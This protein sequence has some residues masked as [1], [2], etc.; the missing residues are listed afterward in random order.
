MWKLTRKIPL[1]L[2]VCWYWITGSRVSRCK[3][4]VPVWI[5]VVMNLNLNFKHFLVIIFYILIFFAKMI[6][7]LKML[8]NYFALNW[9]W[10][11]FINEDKSKN[12]IHAISRTSP[13]PLKIISRI[14]GPV[15]VRWRAKQI[16]ICFWVHRIFHWLR[17]LVRLPSA[18]IFLNKTNEKHQIKLTIDIF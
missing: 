8:H 12:L 16:P 17:F 13:F 18:P 2:V 4:D 15:L 6:K 10:N 11:Q 3:A 5:G 1:K 7:I 9:S 14:E